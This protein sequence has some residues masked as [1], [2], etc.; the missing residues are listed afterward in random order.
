MIL[1]GFVGQKIL[2]QKPSFFLL[3]VLGFAFHGLHDATAQSN[4]KKIVKLNEKVD[5]VIFDY[6]NKMDSVIRQNEQKNKLLVSD[7]ND[8]LNRLNF[9]FQN[10][11]M[12]FDSLKKEVSLDKQQMLKQISNYQNQ[13]ND[14]NLKKKHADSIV[15][16]LNRK[17]LDLNWDN[18]TLKNK[19][20]SK[21]LSNINSLFYNGYSKRYFYTSGDS[22]LVV[23][24]EFFGIGELEGVST[25][26]NLYFNFV[27]QK[28]NQS[29]G[30]DDQKNKFGFY[31]E[32]TYD[33]NLTCT[34]CNRIFLD[35]ETP[36]G[37]IRRDI[38]RG[39]KYKIAFIYY[40][41]LEANRTFPG[42]CTNAGFIIVDIVPLGDKFYRDSQV[43]N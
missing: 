17:L 27:F 42:R 28:N 5:S 2:F 32:P 15:V 33:S 11:A 36:I 14:L 29:I 31:E 43:E 25:G 40:S 10:L 34:N 38:E 7:F 13:I 3:F 22:N 20:D 37:T 9:Q 35:L 4:K 30:F 41:D 6:T 21:N 39:K 12:K 19:L 23:P 26:L 16:N 1:P 18:K 8:K 24:G